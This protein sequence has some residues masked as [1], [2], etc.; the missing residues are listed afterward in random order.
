MMR[1]ARQKQQLGGKNGWSQW[2]VEK[3]VPEKKPTEN[4]EEEVKFS[5]KMKICKRTN[6]M[7]CNAMCVPLCLG[8]D[9]R[10]LRIPQLAGP[11][12]VG[13]NDNDDDGRLGT[14]TR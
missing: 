4:A 10:T 7:Q 11:K 6:A 14:V 8:S 2:M 3:Y 5:N 9:L 12:S 13:V 1:R